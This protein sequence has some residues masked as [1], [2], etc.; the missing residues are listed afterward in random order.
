[1]LTLYDIPPDVSGNITPGGPTVTTTFVAPGQN[2]RLTFAGTAGQKISLNATNGNLSVN[3]A[4]PVTILNPDGTPLLF[5]NSTF[6]WT[7]GFLDNLT[8]PSNGT[9]TIFI[10]PQ[11]ESTGSIDWTLYDTSD[12]TATIT[13]GGAPVTTTTTIPGQNARLTFSGTSGQKVSLLV[14]NV[15]TGNNTVSIYNPDGSVLVSVPWVN[16]NGTFIDGRTLPS[17]GTYAIVFDP[18]YTDT[19]SA[20]FTLYDASDVTATVTLGGPAVNVTTTVPGQNAKLT[21]DGSAGQQVTVHV[22]NN[23]LYNVTVSLVAP[24]GTVLTSNYATGSTMDLA[25]QTLPTAGTY[26]VVV[27]P[28]GASTGSMDVNLTNP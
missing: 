2:A 24:D 6:Y 9:Y 25:T 27:D 20:T 16:T 28:S 21:F 22:R 3:A 15:T 12:V 19:G 7:S 14:S 1:M 13:P 23:N 11:A 8:L 18:A 26:T 17:T 10:D 5:T 4:L